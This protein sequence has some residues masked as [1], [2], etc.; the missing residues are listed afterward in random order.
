MP[1]KH[2]PTNPFSSRDPRTRPACR[3]YLCFRVYFAIRL[4]FVILPDVKFEKFQ[5][6]KVR[7]RHDGKLRRIPVQEQSK[8]VLTHFGTI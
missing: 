1:P 8:H 3:R 7:T 4:Q 2:L 6:C 5:N